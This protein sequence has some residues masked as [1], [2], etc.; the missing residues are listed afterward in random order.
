MDSIADKFASQ[1][2]SIRRWNS[3]AMILIAFSDGSQAGFDASND[4]R[5]MPTGDSG[6][7][8]REF[9]R[10]T[11]TIRS[12]KHGPEVVFLDDS[13]IICTTQNWT[14]MHPG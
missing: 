2:S 10:N 1:I 7:A 9:A 11:K 13:W 8:A 12:G 14:A 4:K 3:P 5:P 6:S